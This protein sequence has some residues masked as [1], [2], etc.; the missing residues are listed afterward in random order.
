MRQLWC[1][2]GLL[3]ACASEPKDIPAGPR[4][5]A[6]VSIDNMENPNCPALV[7]AAVS[8]IHG[9]VRVDA[10][11]E[12]ANAEIEFVEGATSTAAILTVIR[13]DVGFP[14]RVVRLADAGR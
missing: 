10:S 6:T 7:T 4:K 3:A 13:D 9:V 11:L 12:N 5:I 2:L 8:R 1:L 14:A